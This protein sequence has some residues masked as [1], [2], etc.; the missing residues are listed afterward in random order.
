MVFKPL[1]WLRPT[2][3]TPYVASGSHYLPETIRKAAKEQVIMFVL[4]PN[5]THL[6][7]PLDKGCFGP[8][9]VKWR[10]VCH[11]YIISHPGKV[12]NRYVFLVLPNQAWMQAMTMTNILAGF[13][14]T[15]VYPL[16]RQAL[17]PTRERDSLTEVSG[18]AFIPCSSRRDKPNRK[19][20]VFTTKNWRCFREDLRVGTT[21]QRSAIPS[22]LAVS[23]RRC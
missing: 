22:G 1:P 4:P 12:G 3:Q 14:V 18:L 2:C 9:K 16:N 7:Q 8:L 5:T 15:G 21:F 6:T 19:V 10:Q 17:P 23:P 13:R 11:H 20:P